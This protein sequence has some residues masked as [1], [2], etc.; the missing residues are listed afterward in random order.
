MSVV[1]RS[2]KTDQY[3]QG[4]VVPV[5]RT[6]TATCPVAM[7]EHYYRI[8]KIA[9][10]SCLPL[11]RGITNTKFGQRLRASG[12]LSYIQM[13]ELFLAKLEE[14]G[15]MLANLVCIACELAEPP[16]QLM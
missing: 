6:G 3:R 15:L 13:R 16:Q 14:L 4:D 7:M 5:A 10:D 1:I 12:S 11:F 8:G 2:S 9:H